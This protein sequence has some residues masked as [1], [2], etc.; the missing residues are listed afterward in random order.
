MGYLSERRITTYHAFICL[1]SDV[2]VRITTAHCSYPR[3][4]AGFDGCS[5]EHNVHLPPVT[6]TGW[7]ISFLAIFR[8][9]EST[10]CRTYYAFC[11]TQAEDCYTFTTGLRLLLLILHATCFSSSKMTQN[12][13]PSHFA[14]NLKMT[15]WWSSFIWAVF[16]YGQKTDQVYTSR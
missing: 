7:R 8:K 6:H 14:S 16:R 13:E 1:Y 10:Q 15:I 5:R 9:P 11:A 3:S 4:P 12:F 2:S